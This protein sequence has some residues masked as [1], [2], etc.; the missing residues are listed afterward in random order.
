MIPNVSRPTSENAKEF[1]ESFETFLA[2]YYDDRD[3][4]HDR[5]S[6]F[7]QRYPNEQSAF[8]IDYDDL[9]KFD[10]EK[11]DQLVAYPETM[12]EWLEQALRNYDLPGPS[13]SEASVRVNNLPDGLVYDVGDYTT[14]E[15]DALV[16]IQGQVNKVAQSKGNLTEICYECQRCGTKDYIPQT[17]AS[18]RQQPHECAGCERQGPFRILWD[19]SETEDYQLVRVQ[20]P[21]ERSANGAQS[22]SIDVTLTGDLVN[23]V[24][25]GD[26]VVMSSFL[27]RELDDENATT[28]S[29]YARAN[30]VHQKETDFEDL[31]F[32]EYREEIE[33]LSSH[34]N[35]LQQ[36]V[37]SLKPSHRGDAHI[38]EA[39]ALQMFGGVKKVMPDGSKKRAQSHILL[40]GDPGTDKSGLL[41]YA[42]DLSPR[43]VYTSGKNATS[44]GLTCAAV[45]SDFGD[46]GWTLEAGA[47]V[48]AH[49]GLCA[50]DEFDKMDDEDRSGVQE[51]LAQGHISPSK[52]GISNVQLPAETTVLAAANPKYGRFDSYESIGDQIELDPTLISRFDL[53][54]TVR[55]EPDATEDAELADHLNEVAEVGQRLAAGEKVEQSSIDVDIDPDVLRHYIAY[56]KEK[57]TPRLSDDAKEVFKEF[58]VNMRGEGTDEDSP[59]PVTARKL[60]ALHR[61]GEAKARSRLSETITQED[62]QFVVSLVERSLNDVGVDPETGEY[63]AD[64]VETGTSK[65]QREKIQEVADVVSQLESENPNGAPIG[66]VMDTLS[67]MGYTE[68][69]REQYIRRAKEKGAL[70]EPS[71]D[72]L[73]ST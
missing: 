24:T 26:R 62:A 43:S 68:S 28:Y 51:A 23:S 18:D 50:I 45:Q 35:P 5:L 9:E 37:D 2:R 60:E 16:G 34:P 65:A 48:Q 73:R 63:D 15:E 70:Y 64:V 30:H 46:G 27:G 44:A 22:D 13:L 4:G 10:A 59:V 1:V 67:D 58:Y 71:D 19:E 36:V 7:A 3:G 33:E 29:H 12:L 55:D 61:L 42:V 38:K 6:R 25:P 11:A 8:V 57:V 66:E 39:I 31:D 20:R 47:L 72:H 32:D 21:P 53:I 40:V 49:K 56:A 54:F 14:G 17:S 41:E 69:Q 52:A